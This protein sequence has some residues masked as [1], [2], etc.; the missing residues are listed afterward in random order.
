MGANA[1]AVAGVDLT[2]T[3]TPASGAATVTDVTNLPY[4]LGTVISKSSGAQEKRYKF[5]MIVDQTTV[6]GDL[7]CYTTGDNGYSVTNDRS[8][9]TSDNTQPAGLALVVCTVGKCCWIQTYGFSDVAMVTD[10]SLAADEIFKPHA[11]TD[12]GID[13]YAATEVED[14]RAGQVLDADTGTAQPIGTA[15]VDCPKG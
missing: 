2:K 5:V 8:G 15:F 11:T 12:G 1:L 9:G 7:L 10:G 13:S 14:V 3:Y 4:A 6:V